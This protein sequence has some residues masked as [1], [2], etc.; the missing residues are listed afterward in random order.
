MAQKIAWTRRATDDLYAVYESLSAFSDTRAEAVTEE[1]I[2]RVFLL[3][4]FPRLGR[5]VPELNIETI[6]ELV[7]RQYRVVYAFT[8]Q[9]VVEVL[10]VRH[11][12]RPLSEI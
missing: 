10:A 4:N 5:V 8:E 2:N 12:S 9:G 1:I 6:R 3:E 7:V 11:S